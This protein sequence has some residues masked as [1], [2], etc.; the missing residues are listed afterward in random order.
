MMCLFLM[1][2]ICSYFAQTNSNLSQ[3]AN[4]GLLVN[5]GDDCNHFGFGVFLCNAGTANIP[6]D[7]WWLILSANI[8]GTAVQVAFLL[9]GSKMYERYCAAGDWSEWQELRMRPAVKEKGVVLHYKSSTEMYVET[10]AVSTPIS[11]RINRI[12]GTPYDNI[13]SATAVKNGD[14]IRCTAFGKGF[15]EEH[16][17]NVSIIVV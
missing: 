9:W 12:P 5:P 13:I 11:V 15:V 3:K 1:Q 17:L 10:E 6:Y 4:A 16:L 8:D 7:D 14:S 2:N